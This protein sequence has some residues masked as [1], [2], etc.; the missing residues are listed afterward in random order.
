LQSPEKS[1]EPLKSQTA[2]RFY[3]PEKVLL[4]NSALFHALLE[5]K[6]TGEFK[7][8]DDEL[9]YDPK[10]TTHPK[11]LKL[12]YNDKIIY[13]NRM[14]QHMADR[15]DNDAVDILKWARHLGFAALQTWCDWVM[16]GGGEGIKM[17]NS[18]HE[19]K[20]ALKVANFLGAGNGYLKA[21]NDF[22]VAPPKFPEDEELEIQYKKGGLGQ[23]YKKT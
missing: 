18:W 17:V 4:E 13:W 11:D 3:F 21:L 22:N 8:P 20:R 15:K 12:L 19:K 1:S 7:D 2:T 9:V 16:A 23:L 6:R 14:V 5:A 10:V